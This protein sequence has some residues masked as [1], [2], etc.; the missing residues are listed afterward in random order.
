MNMKLYWRVKE[1]GKWV[2]KPARV[3]EHNYNWILVEH[4]NVECETGNEHL[5]MIYPCED[6]VEPLIDELILLDRFEE[7]ETRYV[8]SESEEETRSM[9]EP[10]D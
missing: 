6:D 2:L 5:D 4:W 9:D 3:A 8:R 1:N 10:E 7:G